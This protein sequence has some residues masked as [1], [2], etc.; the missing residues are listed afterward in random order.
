M[1]WYQ[2]VNCNNNN[3]GNNDDNISKINNNNNNN[4]NPVALKYWD[5]ISKVQSSLMA[6]EVLFSLGWIKIPVAV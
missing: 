6:D 5:D 4:N 2:L 1:Q 3:N